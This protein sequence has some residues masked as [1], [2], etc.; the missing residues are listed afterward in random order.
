MLPLRSLGSKI[1]L[2]ATFIALSLTMNACSVAP[3]RTKGDKKPHPNV[4]RARRLPIQGIDVSKW[5]GDINWNA[6]AKAGIHFAFIKATEGGDHIDSKFRDNWL[7]AKRA[8]IPRAGYHFVF[9]C[10]SAEE[11]ATWFIQNVPNEPDALPPVL[12]LEWNHQS[13]NCPKKIPPEEA[14]QMAKTMLEIIEKHTGKRPII[15][16]DIPFHDEVLKGQLHDYPF[17]IRTVAAEPHERYPNRGWTFWQY[18]TTGYV[19]GVS[20][21]VDRNVF[22]GS[23]EQ[24]KSF[25]QTQCDPR[26]VRHLSRKGLCGK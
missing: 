24:W 12:D 16:T 25:M 3:E 19:R 1:I 8:G 10:R 20:G 22:Y 5:Q 18:T 17:W 9:W 6:V 15:Y 4:D 11:Q 2:T 7:G 13:R 26:L 23:S 14:L 21:N